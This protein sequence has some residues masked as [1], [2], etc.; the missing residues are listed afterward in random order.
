MTRPLPRFVNAFTAKGR[1]YYYL[2]RPGAKPIRLPDFGTPE[3]EAEYQRA[4]HGDQ[5]E[6][7]ASRT[8]PG[9]L[10][11]AVVSYYKSLA[12]RELTASSQAMRR[13]YL[14]RFREKYGNSRL[15][16]MPQTFIV[17]MMDRMEPFSA[18]NWFKCV[19]AVMQHAVS[20]GLCKTD[21][22]QGVKLPP[23]KSDGIHA[24]TEGEIARYEA[25]HA[26]G[27]KARLALALALYTGQRRGDLVRMGRQHIRNGAIEVKQAKTRTVLEIPLHA[28]LRAVMEV[29]PSEHL[30]FLT[31]KTGKPYAPNDLSDEFRGWCD[32]AGLPPECSLHGLRKAAARRLAEAGCS[33]HEIAAITPGHKTL[34]EVERYTKSAE[35]A[36]LGRS[37]MAKV[38]NKA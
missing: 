26:I 23:I 27:T 13:S 37:A 32:A 35:Q 22:T 36:R 21:P 15:A 2:R 33:A 34:K 25:H 14:E 6:V 16:I 20:V 38:E 4:L 8:L 12:F 7:G 24:W 29:T 30:T 18:R 31:T 28:N 10:N 17:Q 11:E 5:P 3:F 1:R 19:R 9:T